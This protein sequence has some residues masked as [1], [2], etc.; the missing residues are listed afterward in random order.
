MSQEFD[1]VDYESIPDYYEGLGEDEVVTDL[2][3]Y[4]P[5]AENEETSEGGGSLMWL[6]IPVVI[7]GAGV[8][9]IK[10]KKKNK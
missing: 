7:L 2:E 1:P 4:V 9:L 10:N 3:N 8:V 6:V 5:G